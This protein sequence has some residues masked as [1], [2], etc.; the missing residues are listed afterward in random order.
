MVKVIRVDETATE[1]INITDKFKITVTS[2][3]YKVTAKSQVITQGHRN[4]VQCLELRLL[5][6]AL[7]F[8]K[9]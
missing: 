7:V 5:G 2:T 6:I 4:P 9:T 3:L 1:I 8:N